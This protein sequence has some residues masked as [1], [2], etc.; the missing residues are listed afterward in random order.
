MPFLPIGATMPFDKNLQAP[1]QISKRSRCRIGLTETSVVS[2]HAA[3]RLNKFA[4][5]T[6][7]RA[8]PFVGGCRAVFKAVITA[9]VQTPPTPTLSGHSAADFRFPEADSL[10]SP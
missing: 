5:Y 2:G 6:K 9:M 3:Q 8:S 4:A 1:R 7:S 10:V